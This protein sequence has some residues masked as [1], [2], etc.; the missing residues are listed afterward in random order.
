MRNNFLR[1]AKV[2]N[3][4]LQSHFFNVF[5]YQTPKKGLLLLKC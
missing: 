1:T 4:T 5:F 3:Y 2:S